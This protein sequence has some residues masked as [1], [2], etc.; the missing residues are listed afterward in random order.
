VSTPGKIILAV[1]LAYIGLAFSSLIGGF[2]VGV[3][4][5]ALQLSPAVVR[6]LVWWLPKI[7]FAGMLLLL[8]I[9]WDKRRRANNATQ[10]R[11]E[12]DVTICIFFA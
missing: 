12:L 1:V 6:S 10:D 5:A 9:V 8:F 7:I 2:I 4:G 11:K 3:L